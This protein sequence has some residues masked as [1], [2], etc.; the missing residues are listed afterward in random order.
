MKHPICGLA[1]LALLAVTVPA[2]PDGPT[3][4][5]ALAAIALS[6]HNGSVVQPAVLLE[7]VEIETKLGKLSIPPGEVR[8]IDFGFRLSAEEARKV[9]QAMRD[10]GSNRFQA[11]DAATKALTRM[12]RLAYPA[13]LAGRKNADLETSKRVEAILKDIRARVPASKLQ[14][15]L[16]DILRTSDSIV[17]G[18]ITAAT[19]RVRSELFGELKVPVAQLREV[20]SLLPGSDVNVAVDASKYGS[21][22][23]WLETEFEVTLG[24]RLEITA[25]GEINLDPLNQINNP[26][27]TRGIRPDGIRQLS[28]NEGYLPGQLLGRIGTDGPTFVVGSRYSAHPEREGKLFLRMATI[29]HANNIRAEGSYQ[30]RIT[31]ELN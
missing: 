13:L 18:Q 21:R 24:T 22:T 15:R 1:W 17:A 2:R 6:F 28:S 20:R 30:V 5:P 26:N 3:A 7:A 4:D 9:D 25:T 27:L 16:T 19:F 23:T 29:I 31:A 11:R 12:G 8:R 14:T 10:L